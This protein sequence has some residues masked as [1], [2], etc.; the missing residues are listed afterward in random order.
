MSKKILLIIGILVI[1]GVVAFFVFSPGENSGGSTPNTDTGFSFKDFLPFGQSD[2]ITPSTNTDSTATN[3]QTNLPTNNPNQPVPKLRKIS[4]EPVAGGVVFNSGTTT[5]ARFI[6]KGT[7][8]VY[9]ANSN[10]IRVERLTNTTIPRVIRA[11]WL[12]DGSGFLAQTIAPDSEVIETNFVKLNKAKIATS[13]REETFLPYAT[14]ISKLPTDIKE[15]SVNPTGTKIFYY[16]IGNAGSNW[17]TSNPDGTAATLVNSHPLTEWLPKWITSNTIIMQIKS[18]S[19]SI[20]YTYAFDVANKILRKVGLDSVGLSSLPNNDLSFILSSNGGTAPQLS[21]FDNKTLSLIKGSTNT[22]ADKCA[23]LTKTKVTVLCGV[24]NQLPSGSYPDFWHQGVIST[25]D[26]IRKIDV[27]NDIYYDTID[28]SKES[29]QKIDVY[30]PQLSPDDHQLLFKN[31]ID[32]Y[33]WLL[34]I[35]Q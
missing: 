25:E 15:I 8:N 21:V 35:E 1:V 19:L 12:P 14:T 11:F 34:R 27:I 7:G 30:E 31:K 20:G 32:G 4:N 6:E 16:T 13:T 2:D 28:L 17:Y 18:S 29:G 33:L 10:N 3:D 22:L 23:W 26:S 5:F 9:E 24:P